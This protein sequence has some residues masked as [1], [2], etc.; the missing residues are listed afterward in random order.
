MKLHTLLIFTLSLTASANA[1]SAILDRVVAVVNHRVI[2]QSD[3]AE[4]EAFETLS[5]GRP[6]AAPSYDPAVLQRLIDQSLVTDQI[7]ANQGIGAADDDVSA[8]IAT[9]RQQV[10]PSKD[11]AAWRAM[12]ISYGLDE[13]DFADR[14]RR[15]LNV[16]RFV[17][18]RFRPGIL[19][20]PEEIAGYYR[21][22]LLPDLRKAGTPED[23]LPPIS[24]VEDK[25][26]EVLSERRITEML[27]AWLEALREQSQIKMLVGPSREQTRATKAK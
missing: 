21:D 16:M 5:A 8:Q 25:I 22:V 6:A 7:E 13:A 10:A 18:L 4:E 24:E 14:V 9:V 20:K 3:W 19:V 23:K 2:T 12:L 17:E 15:Q 27:N 26:R 1:Q 11:D